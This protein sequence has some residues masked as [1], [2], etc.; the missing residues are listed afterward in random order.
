MMNVECALFPAV[1]DWPGGKQGPKKQITHREVY[2]HGPKLAIKSDLIYSSE[3][4]RYLTHPEE[5]Y[6]FLPLKTQKELPRSIPVV[7]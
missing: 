2:L 3:T 1:T 6:Y 4:K 7:K 5:I